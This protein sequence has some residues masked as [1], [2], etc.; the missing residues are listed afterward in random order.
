MKL[1]KPQQRA[2]KLAA[3]SYSQKDYPIDSLTIAGNTGK[4]LQKKGLLLVHVDHH[5]AS[6]IYELTNKGIA[7]AKELGYIKDESTSKSE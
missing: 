5:E 4:S 7:V 1:S 3:K 6:R 2:I